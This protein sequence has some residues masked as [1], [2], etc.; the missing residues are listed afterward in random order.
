MG[1]FLAQ[2]KEKQDLEKA[3]EIKAFLENN[4]QE[5]ID[6]FFLAK[7]F[8]MNTRCL[9]IAF[10]ALTDQTPHEYLTRVRIEQAKK[11]LQKTDLNTSLIAARVGLDKTNLYKH[12]K[13]LTGLTPVQW[14]ENAS[15][16]N[17]S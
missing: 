11:L 13:K 8:G 1:S 16:Q 7:K 10:K 9:R 15:T 4:Y 2:W 5:I 17:N 12:F 14:R 3:K 6:A